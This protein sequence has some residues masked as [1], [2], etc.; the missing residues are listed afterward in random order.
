MENN[1]FPIEKVYKTNCY[2]NFCFPGSHGDYNLIHNEKLVEKFDM[3]NERFEKFCETSSSR[4]EAFENRIEQKL[5][6]LE[7]KVESIVEHVKK[8]QIPPPAS[9]SLEGTEKE[10]MLHVSVRNL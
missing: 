6:D 5:C 10:K 2:F 3:L 4:F 7:R 9:A 8:S 1:N